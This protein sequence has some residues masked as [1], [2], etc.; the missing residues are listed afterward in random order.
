MRDGHF[1]AVTGD[2]VNDAPAM[3]QAH[4]GIEQGRV[5]YNN[6]R[7]VI[8]LL[9]ATGFSAIL[10]FFC[11]LAGLPMPM[12]AVQLLWLNLVANGFQDVALAFEPKEG[13]E[14]VPAQ[15]GT[16]TLPHL[17]VSHNSKQATAKRSTAKWTARYF[18][19]VGAGFL[20]KLK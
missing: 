6:I 1:V 4:A 9:V 16:H 7:K 17:P 18:W 5:V 10:L 11:V 12:I 2:G 14:P 19:V 20:V 8:G 15:R 3:R 13:G